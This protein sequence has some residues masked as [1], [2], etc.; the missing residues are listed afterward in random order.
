M[1]EG[2]SSLQT[3]DLRGNPGAPFTLTLALV[4]TDTMDRAAPGPATVVAQLAQGAPFE[5]TVTYLS[6]EEHYQQPQR[7]LQGARSK[8]TPSR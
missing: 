2:L 1:F 6:K 4:R 5:M 7:R 8:A 3:L